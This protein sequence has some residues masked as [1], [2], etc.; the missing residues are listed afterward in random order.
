VEM[1]LTPD[2]HAAAS[3][4]EADITWGVRGV[5]GFDTGGVVEL[6]GSNDVDV[7]RGAS[8][9]PGG[10]SHPQLTER[11]VAAGEDEPGVAAL[12]LDDLV[13]SGGQHAR[14]TAA[15]ENRFARCFAVAVRLDGGSA[16]GR[17]DIGQHLARERRNV[18]CVAINWLHFDWSSNSTVGAIRIDDRAFRGR[19]AMRVMFDPT[20][21]DSTLPLAFTRESPKSTKAPVEDDSCATTLVAKS[22]AR[23]SAPRARTTIRF[24]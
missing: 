13:T 9:H 3:G 1:R 2:E 14:F 24:I 15:D 18:P 19:R 16:A 6:D 21:P 17:A 20:S 12:N 22:A 8:E 10:T 11:V 4:R 23:D 5:L 7:R